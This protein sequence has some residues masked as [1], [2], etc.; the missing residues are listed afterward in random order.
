[1]EYL[2]HSANCDGKSQSYEDHILAVMR[3]ADRYAA[4]AGKYARTSCLELQHTVHNAALWHD[5]G[6]LDK[7]NQDVLRSTQDGKGHLPVNHVDA[8]CSYLL[9][10]GSLLAALSVYSHHAGL[11]DIAEEQARGMNFLRDK[12]IKRQTDNELGELVSIHESLTSA[13]AAD[14]TLEKTPNGL[15]VYCRMALSCLADADHSDTA[16]F[17]GQGPSAEDMPLLRAD[18]RLRMLDQYVS[19]LG[20]NDERSRLRRKMYR[21]CRSANLEESFVSCDSPVG[22]G[23]TTAVMANLLHQC[24]EYGLR[25]IFVVLPYTSIISQSVKVYRKALVL[26]GEDPNR[27]VAEVHSRVDF[28]D[29]DTRYLTAR[30]KAPIVV[31]TAVAF[32][33][34]LASNKP[35]VLRRLHELPGSVIFVDEAHAALPVQLLPIAWKWMNCLAEEWSCRWVLASGSLVRFWELSAFKHWKIGLEQPDVTRLVPEAIRA[36]LYKY[37]LNRIRY[38]YREQAIALSDFPTWVCGEPGPRLVI[39][40]T[41][42]NAAIV[43]DA[44]RQ[45]CGRE[46]VEHLSTALTPGYRAKTVERIIKRLSNEEDT[47]WTLVAT[48]CVEAGVDFSFRT[49]FRETSSLLS[50]VQSAGRVNRNGE[51]DAAEMWTFLFQDD[52]RLNNNKRLKASREVLLN[53]FKKS[54]PVNAE[55]STTS[56]NEELSWGSNERVRLFIRKLLDD[57]GD[58]EFKE[59]ASEF[60]VIDDDTVVAIIDPELAERAVR[61]YSCWENLQS[62]S[63][64][65]RKCYIGKWQLQKLSED[66]YQWTLPYDD[67]LG[68]MRGVMELGQFTNGTLIL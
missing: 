64:S 16:R 6:K 63:V 48:S 8:G 68:Y 13:D 65:I 21:A 14:H 23:K 38:C 59:I 41:V 52:S 30:W 7:D 19:D 44:F 28:E 33:E 39:V 67:F 45:E 54:I 36:E 1:M 53:Y 17:Y 55:L 24:S 22:S 29:Y 11:P 34:T 20:T 43:A 49:G 5:L 56:M 3:R 12:Q 40:N 27:V 42:N 57:E 47:D 60:K 2:A 35:S 4:E 31:T 10:S 61:G 66:L 50:L 15:G 37:E 18:E 25:R 58:Y 32:F 26:P 46:R 9:K 51:Y 62:G